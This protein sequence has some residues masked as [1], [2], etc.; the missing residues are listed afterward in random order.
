LDFFTFFAYSTTLSVLVP[1][2]ISIVKFK[3]LDKSLRLLNLYLLITSVKEIACLY[4]AFKHQNNLFIYNSFRIVEFALLPLMFQYK[5]TN[6]KL[7]HAIKYIIGGVFL[8][9]I[10]NLVFFQGLYVF[11][12]YTIIVGRIALIFITLTFFFELLQK[13]ETTSLYR[14]PMLWIST[15][16]LFYSVGS[17]LIHGLYDLQL[18]FS[19]DLSI[20]IWAINSVLNLM[21][22]ILYSIAF[23]CLPKSQK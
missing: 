20:K 4:L 17:F 9:Y 7:K 2:F 13:V 16:I 19:Q 22:N 5:L 3:S 12:T 23:L 1:T 8:V 18:H 14:E 11:N 10:I 6:G 15:G 21:L